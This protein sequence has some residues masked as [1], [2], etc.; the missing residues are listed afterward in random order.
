[1][2]SPFV[3]REVISSGSSSHPLYFSKRNKTSQTRWTRK[4]CTCGGYHNHFNQS[5]FNTKVQ[6]FWEGHKNGRNRPHGFEIYL[7]MVKTMWTIAQIFVA[8]SKKL[9]FT[10]LFR[11]VVRNRIFFPGPTAL[12]KALRLLNFGIFP[13]VYRYFQVWWF[14]CN[15]NLHIL[16]MP[17]VYSRPYVYSF[18]Q[19]FQ[20][21]RL[22]PALRL[23]QTLEYSVC[24]LNLK[25]YLAQSFHKTH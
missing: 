3:F 24:I 22:F 15:I 21:L 7:V 9:N 8:F 1:M 2:I 10:S 19:I 18:W 13:R 5:V 14:F 6:L 11:E 4:K 17:Y 25:I 20:A 12:L 16:F 23:F